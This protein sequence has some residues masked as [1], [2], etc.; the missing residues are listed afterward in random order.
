MNKEC[1]FELTFQY[2]P[3]DLHVKDK[4]LFIKNQIIN[5][6]EKNI[7][8]GLYIN[9]VISI[10][11]MKK[12]EIKYDGVI[13]ISY[14]CVCNIIDPHIDDILTIHINDINK[15]GYIYKENKLCMFISNI[16]I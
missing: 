9:H 5:K 11:L 4:I 7:I 1:S 10:D 2:Y 6:L 15:M 8:N 3:K 16:S 13:D 12:T 14:T